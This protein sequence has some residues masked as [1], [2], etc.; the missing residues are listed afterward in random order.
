MLI[1]IVILVL[2]LQ[3]QMEAEQSQVV[4]EVLQLALSRAADDMKLQGGSIA[5]E[6]DLRHIVS[7]TALSAGG[8]TRSRFSNKEPREANKGVE[9]S[10]L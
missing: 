4:A 1:M 9:E 3:V 10:P 2:F 7:H 6:S 5:S 8:G